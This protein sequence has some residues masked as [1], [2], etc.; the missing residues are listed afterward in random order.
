[1]E[2]KA[3]IRSLLEELQ[4]LEVDSAIIFYLKENYYGE[5]EK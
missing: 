1:V 5:E 2:H 4:D 3:T